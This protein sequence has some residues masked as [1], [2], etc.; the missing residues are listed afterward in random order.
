MYIQTAKAIAPTA[1]RKLTPA[2][3]FRT[4]FL[5]EEELDVF[6]EKYDNTPEH[7][8]LKTYFVQNF[9]HSDLKRQLLNLGNFL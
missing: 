7:R 2:I 1:V 9:D 4:L 3:T 8:F 5:N 6:S